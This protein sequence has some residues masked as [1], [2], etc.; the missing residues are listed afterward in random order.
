MG[1]DIQGGISE[2][3]WSCRGSM[4]TMHICLCYV[5]KRASRVERDESKP[6]GIGGE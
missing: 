1:E 6:F 3:W 4:Q 5:I 2:N